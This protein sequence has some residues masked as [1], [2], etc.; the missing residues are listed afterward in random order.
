MDENVVWLFFYL[1][2]KVIMIRSTIGLRFKSL[3]DLLALHHALQNSLKTLLALY[4]RFH[5]GLLGFPMILVNVVL[6]WFC[7]TTWN[8]D[9]NL[10][11]LFISSLPNLVIQT[12]F[13]GADQILLSSNIN[14][15]DSDVIFLDQFQDFCVEQV[16]STGSEL[17]WSLLED[18]IAYL[19][20]L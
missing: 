16:S 17:D 5:N 19:L 2:H 3:F 12:D 9:L 20:D 10:V 14:H 11:V 7:A 4:H 15:W 1:I 6:Q 8:L 18:V 13:V